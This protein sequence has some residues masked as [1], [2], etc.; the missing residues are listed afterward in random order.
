M[1]SKSE[2]SQ[3]TIRGGVLWGELGDICTPS[4]N[5]EGFNCKLQIQWD[6]MLLCMV[7][8]VDAI[9]ESS[10]HLLFLK[11]WEKWKRWESSTK[12]DRTSE[13]TDDT[14]V[15]ELDTTVEVE[16]FHCN[17]LKS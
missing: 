6:C 8:L 14:W 15:E 5:W 7:S 11:S 2:A 17:W 3:K 12:F 16:H 9:N 4:T 10:F 13:G 1:L